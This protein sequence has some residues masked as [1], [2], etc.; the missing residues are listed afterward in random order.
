M[1][2]LDVDRSF[3]IGTVDLGWVGNRSFKSTDLASPMRQKGGG[4]NVFLHLEP[5]LSTEPQSKQIAHSQL[6]LESVDGKILDDR[7]AELGRNHR[8][9]G[10][11]PADHEV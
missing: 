3:G 10:R 5:A 9:L 4:I 11:L 1:A 2:G 8:M 6:S 7:N